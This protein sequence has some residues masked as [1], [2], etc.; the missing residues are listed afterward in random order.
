MEEARELHVPR[1]RF[2]FRGGVKRT[3]V[4]AA[5]ARAAEADSAREAKRAAA[6]DR[7]AD[8]S[9]LVP[10][11]RARCGRAAHSA[12]AASGSGPLTARATRRWWCRPQTCAETSRMCGCPASPTAS[13]LCACCGAVRQPRAGGDA[14][15][16][17]VGCGWRPARGRADRLHAV[18]RR[19]RRQRAA[20]EL[21]GLRAAHCG[22]AG[23]RSGVA[24]RCEPWLM[25]R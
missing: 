22:A 18:R 6:Q 17:Q 11:A 4:G 15:R 25:R 8:A 16:T 23:A 3:T 19:C 9:G 20:A 5:A 2:R 14:P 12:L 24:A 7:A 13:W 1:R 21:R 10:C